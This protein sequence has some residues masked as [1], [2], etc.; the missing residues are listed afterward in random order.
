MEN[1]TPVCSSI[2]SAATAKSAGSRRTTVQYWET[3]QALIA[4]F[5]CQFSYYIFKMLPQNETGI[6]PAFA[7]L[8][9]CNRIKKL[10]GLHANTG[11][12]SFHH[13]P[14]HITAGIKNKPQQHIA[15][16]LLYAA[17]GHINCPF[18]IFWQCG[19]TCRHL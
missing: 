17:V 3:E 4:H 18:I 19:T 9:V 6:A 5:F 2:F 15:A 11:A 16:M 13:I 10:Q 14:P 12:K 1:G 8:T 7:L